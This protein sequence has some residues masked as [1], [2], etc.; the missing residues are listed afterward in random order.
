MQAKQP[1]FAAL[2]LTITSS[3]IADPCG[4]VPPIYQGAGTP[5]SRQGEQITYVFYQNGVESCV[6][7]PG[8]KCKVDEIGMFITVPRPPA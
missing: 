3:A 4:M 7:R 1:M 5:I 2:L 6:N 8:F